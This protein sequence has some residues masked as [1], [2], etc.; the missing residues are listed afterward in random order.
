MHSQGSSGDGVPKRRPRPRAAPA[1][2]RG[3]RPP[4][5]LH[6]QG[7]LPPGVRPTALRRLLAGVA[8]ALGRDRAEVTVRFADDRT[9]RR[10][11]RRWRRVDRPTDV[12]SFPA[13]DEPDGLD[14]DLLLSRDRVRVQARRAGLSAEREAMELVLHGL[15][16]LAG[17]DHEA[18]QGEMDRLELRL[19]RRLLDP[20]GGGGAA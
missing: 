18:D 3:R 9:V 20:V 6:V 16:H 4:P 14:G 8:D 5:V 15:L 1:P 19:R 17:F 2:D 12:L 7:R 10:Y 13:A 11:N